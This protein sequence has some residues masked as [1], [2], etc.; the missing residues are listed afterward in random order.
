MT[1]NSEAESTCPTCGATIPPEAPGALCPACLLRDSQTESPASAATQGTPSIEQIAEVFP[2][3]EILELVGRGGMGAVYRAR[4]IKLDREVALKILLPNLSSDPAFAE[5]FEREARALAKLNHPNIVTV[6]DFGDREGL[7][8]LLLEYVDGVNLRGAMST[9]RFTP[10][11]ALAVVP[12]ICDALQSA[13]ELGVLHRDIKPEN[14]LLD[15]GGKVK[16]VDFGIARMVGDPA[17]DFTLTEAG[18]VLGSRNY[19]APEQLEQLNEVDH[20][21]DIYSLGVVFYEMLTGELPMGRFLPPSEKS[22]TTEQ[23]DAIVMRT[24]EKELDRRFQSAGAVKTSIENVSTSSAPPPLP[25]GEPQTTPPAKEKPKSPAPITPRGWIG[26]ISGVIIFTVILLLS[27]GVFLIA[28]VALESSAG[29]GLMAIVGSLCGLLGFAGSWLGLNAIR[30]KQLPAGGLGLLRFLVVAVPALTFG[31]IS[32]MLAIELPYRGKGLFYYVALIPLA[33]TALVTLPAAKWSRFTIKHRL[34]RVLLFCLLVPGTIALFSMTFLYDGRYPYA[35]SHATGTIKFTAAQNLPDQ[36]MLREAAYSAAGPFINDYALTVTSDEVHISV[37]HEEFKRDKSAIP[38][39]ES[40][41]LRTLDQLPVEYLPHVELT[42]SRD[43]NRG[44]DRASA[45]DSLPFFAIGGA[46]IG[47]TIALLGAG[48]SVTTLAISLAVSTAGILLPALP[49]PKS[50]G[51]VVSGDPP[52]SDPPTRAAPSFRTVDN[53]VQTV[54]EAAIAD[55]HEVLLLC[56]SE[57]IPNSKKEYNAKNLTRMASSGY[58]ILSHSDGLPPAE[59]SQ[60]DAK[61]E[62]RLI[63]RGG[64]S[65]KTMRFEIMEE[66]GLWKVYNN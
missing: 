24:L 66:D 16:I 25:H 62:V 33:S 50:M 15:R 57:E 51:R 42:T 14:I 11:Q 27:A 65:T 26:D 22:P 38:H 34:L 9:G 21:A 12:G 35:H 6:F 32:V 31:F 17:S 60:A 46:V 19:M 37:V 54:V 52:A 1:T 2:E 7:F 28:G 47:L 23:I 49:Y 48:V 56:L 40:F 41:F 4:Q 10:E 43:S 44:D 8:Y 53:L 3:L 13:H 36:K 64:D 59:N 5:R 63:S 39:V 18:A 29:S 55:D 30:K 58:R 45:Y 61:V 20:R